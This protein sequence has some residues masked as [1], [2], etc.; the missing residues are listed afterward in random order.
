MKLNM[1]SEFKQTNKQKTPH[2]KHLQTSRPSRKP[3]HEIYAG[4][5]GSFLGARLIN[6]IWVIF[7][8]PRGIRAEWVTFGWDATWMTPVGKFTNCEVTRFATFHGFVQLFLH[9]YT[10]LRFVLFIYKSIKVKKCIWSS[11]Q[12]INQYINQHKG[13]PKK[14]LWRHLWTVIAGHTWPY[15]VKWRGEMTTFLDLIC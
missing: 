2:T 12:N 9:L 6:L 5:G 13:R 3:K 15:M 11:H 8:P 1:S 10:G 4:L 14:Y 7:S